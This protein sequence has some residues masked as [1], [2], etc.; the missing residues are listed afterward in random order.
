MDNSHDNVTEHDDIT[1]LANQ[2][3]ETYRR[4]CAELVSHYNR[5]KSALDGYRGRQLLELLQNADDAGVENN[6]DCDLV[7]D[8]SRERLIVANTGKPFTKKGITSLVISDCSPK[9]LDR[10]RFIGCK[11]LGF[12]SVLTWTDQP[13]ISSG[14]Y[15]VSFDRDLAIKTVQKL[16]DESPGLL[17]MIKPFLDSGQGWPVAA[18]RFPAIPHESDSR[19]L[20]AK[21]YRAQ[22]FD[23]V[24][25]IPIP[26]EKVGDAIY[27]EV[28]EQLNGL[29]TNC[30]LFCQHL[31][32]VQVSGDLEK[33]WKL[34]REPHDEEHTSVIIQDNDGEPELWQVYRHADQVS[35]SLGQMHLSGRRD[36]EVAIAV[37][38]RPI[39]NPQGSLYVF[40]PTGEKL[41]CGL[42]MHATLETTDDRNHFVDHPSNREVLRGL[43]KLAAQTIEREST[44]SSSSRALELLSGIEQ[45]DSSLRSLGFIDSLIE[46]CGKRRIFPRI[47][48][49]LSSSS[50]VK[51][52]PNQTWLDLVSKEY[53][54]EVMSIS[55]ERFIGILDLF[56][57]SWFEN[58]ILKSRLKSQL[59]NKPR[60]EAGEII[61]KLLITNQLKEI[62]ADGLLM[63]NEGQLMDGSCFFTPLEK[64]PSIPE[65]AS[66]I[67]FVDEDFQKGLLAGSKINN[68]RTLSAYLSLS[69]CEVQEYS[70]EPVARSLIAL[71]EEAPESDGAA[72]RTRWTELLRWLF[73]AWRGTH[74][75]L[76][77]LMI[78]V[79]TT[80]QSLRR[81]NT[82]YL[83]PRYPNG[84]IVWRLYQVFNEDEFVGAPFENGLNDIAISDV[85][86]FLLAAG[87]NATPRYTRFRSGEEYELFKESI[88]DRLD[89]PRTIQGQMCRTPTE[90]RK[91]CRDYEIDDIFIPDRWIRLLKEGDAA[92][93][94]GY[95]LSFGV[96]IAEEIDSHATF[97]SRMGTQLKLW[98][99]VS[100]PILNAALFF[101][102]GLDWIPGEDGNRHHPSGI[103]LS[104]QGAR[105]LRGIYSRHAID[106]KDTLISLY[107][108]RQALESL[109]TRL[110]AVSS[111]ETLNGQSLYELL[112]SLPER[113]PKGV[114]APGIYR[115]LVDS[116]IHS[117]ESSYRDTFIKNGKMWGKH[118][119]SESYIPI[120]QL[121]Y[122]A[123]L[124]VTKP[125]ESYIALVDIPPR[126]NS[127]VIQDIFGVVP[128]TSKEID[129]NLI[130]EGTIYSQSSED[131]N[132]RLHL[133]IPYIYALRLFDTMDANSRE[134]NLLRKANL[135]V[136]ARLE[137]SA[138]LPGD[139]NEKITLDESGDSIVI[140]TGLFI[141]GEYRENGPG[142]LTF[143][144]S[145]AELVAQLLGPDIAD[146]V[147]GILRCRTTSEMT[148]VLHVRLGPIAEH[149]LKEANDRFDETFKEEAEEQY[150]PIPPAKPTEPPGQTAKPIVETAEPQS[151]PTEGKEP[152]E[153][154]SIPA[155]GTEFLP[156]RGPGERPTKKRKLVITGSGGGGGG[157]RG[158]LATEDITFKVVE[159]FEKDQSRFIIPVSHL[160]GAD[161]FGC[162]LLSV[163]SEAIRDDAIRLRVVS[164]SDIV[165]YIEVKGRSSR[166]GEVELLDNEYRAAEQE[167][168]RYFI[169]RVYV[170]PSHNRH[171]EIAVLPN[172]LNSK[173]VRTV[174]RFNL[175]EGSGASWFKCVETSEDGNID[176]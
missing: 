9:Q 163:A 49:Y 112:L 89:Y 131:A 102:R 136:C 110:G 124:S 141:V 90:V 78:K 38:Q 121:R 138:K 66:S 33:H 115:T 135:R 19:L 1:E 133:A 18:M 103:M 39:D 14:N 151:Q 7:I 26:R 17:E 63:S 91:V 132:R 76:S 34:L 4:Q 130:P 54:P 35:E 98:P 53:F 77:Q 67:R 142:F 158:P 43:A 152:G 171:Y 10:N 155:V 100:V 72:L 175:V 157:G 145:V 73:E 59:I 116:N 148:E 154:S 46:E 56:N 20:E 87:V 109:F 97:C 118:K 32:N 123:N 51:R 94:I 23:T 79:I 84:Q 45:A 50:E 11:G 48:G 5:E 81:A 111:L 173:A 55:A 166:T 3:I 167:T 147:G 150:R 144:L 12:R 22:G 172:P 2:Q 162:D 127:S 62:G 30:L 21:Q 16:V 170:D 140:D 71:V 61:G 8:L 153:P 105:I 106:T 47:D 125:I 114:M 82:C 107:G 119:T 41:P 27:K 104:N 75:S 129:I 88:V 176:Q 28:Y 65:W 126:K 24:V 139:I 122:N 96:Q 70:L 108:G 174:T 68:L 13:L 134:L 143:W 37:P 156:V 36:F 83:G 57:L 169:Y 44:P 113:D 149:K 86:R 80:K 40:F 137:I 95:L 101:L 99:D 25:V 69:N 93:V 15:E 120:Q 52:A 159:A 165:R 128:L 31:V 6:E 60:V 164:E 92:A 146:E 42:V 74:P 161:A 64:L 168:D 160:H 117:D 58:D 85:E 29:Q